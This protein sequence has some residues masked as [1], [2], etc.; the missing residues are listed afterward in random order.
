[1]SRL[2]GFFGCFAALIAV[3]S[4]ALG[5]HALEERLLAAGT[6][7]AWQ[8]AV[9]YHMWHALALLVLAIMPCGGRVRHWAAGCFVAGLLL[10]SGSLYALALGGPGWLGPVTPLGGLALMAGWGAL[11][12]AC[13]RRPNTEP[14]EPPC[15][16][17]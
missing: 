10:F 11:A 2:Y 6:L 9:D 14:A 3:V 12:L 17:A 15:P 13:L 8:T 5:A 1:M 4:G 7:A 16:N